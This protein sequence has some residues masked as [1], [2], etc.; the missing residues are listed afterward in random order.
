MHSFEVHSNE[1]ACRKS[2][3]LGLEHVQCDPDDAMVVV[4]SPPPSY[5]ATT[6]IERIHLLTQLVMMTLVE[7]CLFSYNYSCRAIYL[8]LY[9]LSESPIIETGGFIPG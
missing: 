4:S 3:C 7:C 5:E 8:Y 9:K 1:S 2:G 6:F